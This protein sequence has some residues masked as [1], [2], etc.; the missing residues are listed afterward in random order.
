MSIRE[1]CQK[2]ACDCTADSIIRFLCEKNFSTLQNKKPLNL[3]LTAKDRAN[4]GLNDS[5]SRF[6]E[7]GIAGYIELDDG[8]S[9]PVF[10]V[11]LT[12][13]SLNER[14]CRK[15][16]FDYA[17]HLLP[18]VSSNWDIYNLPSPCSNGIFVFADNQK[19]F[20]MSLIE[21]VEK[22]KNRVRYRRYTFYVDPEAT[23]RTFIERMAMDWSTFDN[24]KEAFS[25][26]RLSDEFFE[27]YKAH[28]ADFVAFATGKRMKEVKNKWLEVD[29]EHEKRKE[30]IMSQFA[31]FG[32]ADKAFRDYVKK[33]MGRLVFL[34]FLAKKGWLGVPE[35]EAWGK[36]DRK[37]LQNLFN[38]KSKEIQDNFLEKVLEPLF[39]D[40][41]NTDRK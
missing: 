38:S 28:Y 17:K 24:I 14:S 29:D 1:I 36:G 7:P 8:T 37:Y 4:C 27:K 20:R 25:V 21:G 15:L 23:N 11:R 31:K 30:D 2:L 19:H 32:N 41:L 33:M 39:F 13:G 6:S 12:D 18:F 40:T 35:G 10:C 26:E 16:Q 22:E 5:F 3:N 34:Q 9:L